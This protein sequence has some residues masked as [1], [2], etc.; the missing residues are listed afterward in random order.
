MT[1]PRD[2]PVPT[3][4][5]NGR[6]VPVPPGASLGGDGPRVIIR[7]SGPIQP[8][9]QAEVT[10]AGGSVAFWCP[11]FG[12]CVTLTEPRLQASA[13]IKALPFVAG[14]V[15]YAEDQCDRGLVRSQDGAGWRW[16]DVICFSSGQRPDVARA[17]IG[18][19][20][21][22]LDQ[23][24]SK[25][26]VDWPGD[27]TPIRE[28]VGVKLVE[29]PRL[30]R[31]LHVGLAS[32]IGDDTP[33]G[34]WATDLDG[35]GEIVGFADTGLDTGVADTVGADIAGRVKRIVSWP[36][37]PSWASFVSNPG[38]DDGPADR[39]SGH[40]TYVTGVAT[41][42]GAAS[43]GAHRGVA[44]RSRIVFQA[45]QQFVQVAPG[46]PE[47][48]PSGYQLAGRP[49]DLRDLFTKAYGL[50]ARIQVN[51]WGTTA[52][53]NYDNDCYEAD[54]F[55]SEHRSAIVLFAAGNEGS[56]ADGNRRIDPGSLESPAV[57]KNVLSIGATE[58]SQVIGYSGSWANL[59][60]EGRMFGN[61]TDRADA[62]AGQPD[63]MALLSSAGPTHDGRIKPDVCAPGTDIVGPR[64]SLATGTGWGPVSPTPHYMVDGGTSVAVAVA[65]GAV[66]LIRQ[67]WRTAGHGRAPSGPA[68]KALVVV[69]AAPVRSRDGTKA[70][71][72]MIAGFGRIDVGESLPV[73][74]S[75]DS[76][77][78]LSD[79]TAA[80]AART[81]STRAFA[82]TL[83]AAGRLRA[84]LCWYDVP[85]EHL[86]NNLDLS[87]TGPGLSA[88]VWGNHPPA[89]AGFPDL[90]NTVE[91][92][93]IDALP[94]GTYHLTV[95]GTN[96]PSGRQPFAL[97]VKG[98]AISSSH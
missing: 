38:A 5:V 84:V 61:A 48:G 73:T 77:L 76:V 46:H 17:L 45:I 92:I 95:G 32:D 63:R 26:R 8:T 96:V 44:P 65:G 74:S 20:A 21:T 82:V 53:A 70:E 86:I 24:H 90:L 11:P 78:L 93:D 91:V 39:D 33:A 51:A 54:L 56:D 71:D 47:M 29:R 80:G 23:A 1:T 43:G 12:A 59:Q 67:A 34:S 81:G 72:R 37:N 52:H 69:G 30:P 98:R 62:V 60:T 40:G 9:W 57:A 50:G 4:W 75:G 97:V 19:G 14:F 7:C 3:V 66:A 10:A 16:L 68:L 6:P 58:G 15:P 18:L 89:A 64:S 2:P 88:P 42:D 55:L 41:G 28:L 36:I 13:A 49:T 22:I 35:T 87:I 31:L 94:A 25:I 27:S 85:G 79:A 83:P